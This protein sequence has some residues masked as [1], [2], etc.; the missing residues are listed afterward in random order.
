[1]GDVGEGVVDALIEMHTFNV[2]LLGQALQTFTS[3]FLPFAWR[4]RLA[5]LASG[6]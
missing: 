3:A 4:T 6:D 1:M 2:K 5:Y